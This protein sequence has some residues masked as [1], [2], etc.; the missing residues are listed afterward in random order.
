MK[1][2]PDRHLLRKTKR[3]ARHKA[4]PSGSKIGFHGG[5]LTVLNQRR[6]LRRRVES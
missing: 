5:E 2:T 4:N 3:G 6:A 1:R